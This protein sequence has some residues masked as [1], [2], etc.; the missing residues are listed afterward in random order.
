MG[1]SPIIHI[2]RLQLEMIHSSF[3]PTYPRR[4]SDD[5]IA[6][7]SGISR[8]GLAACAIAG[9]KKNGTEMG[10]ESDGNGA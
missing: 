4:N 7:R 10:G 5:K 3:L 9:S 6:Y 2:N 8:G 1:K